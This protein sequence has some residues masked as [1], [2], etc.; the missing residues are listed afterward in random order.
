MDDNNN[1][2]QIFGLQNRNTTGNKERCGYCYWP[3]RFPSPP[4]LTAPVLYTAPA[5]R[6]S[7]YTRPP[8]PTQLFF[9]YCSL[10][11]KTVTRL[12]IS[13]PTV[14]TCIDLTRPFA[15]MRFCR[16]TKS[17]VTHDNSVRTVLVAITRRLTEFLLLLLL[18]P[19]A[20]YAKIFIVSS[21]LPSTKHGLSLSLS[22]TLHKHPKKPPRHSQHPNNR[23][24]VVNYTI[25]PG[26]L[27]GAFINV[28]PNVSPI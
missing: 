19:Y 23:L 17:T 3:K 9:F 26:L 20:L 22:R 4:V 5:S 24:A 6:P 18:P 11:R 28:V 8:S 15:G 14:P 12:R 1:G 7:S 21:S 16:I 27:F 25:R 10:R 13:L 2:G